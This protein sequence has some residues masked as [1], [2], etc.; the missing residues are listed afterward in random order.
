MLRHPSQTAFLCV[1][2]GQLNQ[3]MHPLKS[4]PTNADNEDDV[5]IFAA[6]NHGQQPGAGDGGRPREGV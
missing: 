4:V 6:D 5:D 2:L 3:L 1:I